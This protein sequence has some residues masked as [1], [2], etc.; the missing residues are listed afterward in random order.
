MFILY[1]A[2]FHS[3]PWFLTDCA[4]SRNEIGYQ[5]AIPDNLRKEKKEIPIK[6]KEIFRET[7]R[8]VTVVLFWDLRT[9]H[10][11]RRP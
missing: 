3:S 7:I 5:R 8:K 11:R 4:D 9:F 10:P 2:I 1:L 6:L